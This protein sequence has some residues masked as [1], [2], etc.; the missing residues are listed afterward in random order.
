MKVLKITLTS[1]LLSIISVGCAAS[2]S[3]SEAGCVWVPPFEASPAQAAPN[4][5]FQLHGEGF[6]RDFY[7][8]DT[9]GSGAASDGSAY[10]ASQPDKSVKIEFRQGS[11]TWRLATVDAAP[12]ASFDA[13]LRVPGEVKP[14]EATVTATGNFGTAR[15][16]FRVL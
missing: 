7:C 4:E 11:Q 13:E 16:E 2:S 1:I 14:G 9:G 8:D 6:T 5:T 10:R 15:T 12:N 3:S